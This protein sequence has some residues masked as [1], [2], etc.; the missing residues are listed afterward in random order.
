VGDGLHSNQTHLRRLALA[1]A[2]R[3]TWKKTKAA[4]STISSITATFP[5]KS[6]AFMP[7]VYPPLTPS[8]MDKSNYRR[9]AFDA[10][11]EEG[12][13]TQ[14]QAIRGMPANRL[15]QV[16]ASSGILQTQRS[17]AVGP[18]TRC[19]RRHASA[20]HVLFVTTHQGGAT[21]SLMSGAATSAGSSRGRWVKARTPGG[22][23]EARRVG[24][25]WLGP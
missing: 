11:H 23:G 24:R 14:N 16:S 12:A 4:Y 3:Q 13:G 9:S 22:A 7:R 19:S 8:A 20:H 10:S 2:D 17:V 18:S 25:R 5:T 21:W 15:S 1:G 6:S